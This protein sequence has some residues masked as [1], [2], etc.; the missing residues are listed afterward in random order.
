MKVHEYLRKECVAF[1]E[2][3]V[4]K[5]SEERRIQDI[6]VVKDH[7]EVFLDDWSGLPCLDK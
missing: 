7:P 5:K 2:L 1:L 3:I 6:P 4:E